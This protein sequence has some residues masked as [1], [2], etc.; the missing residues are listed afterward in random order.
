MADNGE[1]ILVEFDY[2]NIFVA[3]PNK[4]IDSDGRAKQRLVK[5]ENLVMYA[6]LEAEVIPRSKLTVG[7]ESSE[8]QTVSIAKI[9]FLNPSGE[10]YLTSN[11]IDAFTADQT[12]PKTNNKPNFFRSYED[13]PSL[14]S[15]AVTE[16]SLLGITQIQVKTTLSFMPEVSITLEDVR[17]RA[18]FELGDKSPYAAFFN[19]P[20]PKFY[21]TMKG[22]YGQAIRYQLMLQNFNASFDTNSGNFVV[23]LKFLT[24]KYSM[25]SEITMAYLTAAPYMYK[26][27]LQIKQP[28]LNP[29]ANLATL[30]DGQVYGGYEKIS[31]V[32]DE[33]ISKGLI[34]ADFP[35]LTLQQFQKK[36]DTFIKEVLLSFG[37]VNMQP[38]TD[39]DTYNNDLINYQKEVYNTEPG[40]TSWFTNYMDPNGVII[41][42]DTKQ[43][44]YPFKKNINPNDAI[45]ACK[46][47]GT[48]LINN[49]KKLDEN[50][51]MGKKG[52]FEVKN[53]VLYKSGGIATTLLQVD[54][55]NVVDNLPEWMVSKIKPNDVDFTA[56][57]LAQGNFISTNPAFTGSQDTFTE[58]LTLELNIPKNTGAT[59]YFF[60]FEGKNVDGLDA[61]IERTKKMNKELIQKRGEV[62]KKITD[63]L[64]KLLKDGSPFSIGFIPTIRNVLAVFFA[65]GE[66]F[67]RLMD[68]V[69]KKAYNQKDSDIRK[70]VVLNKTNSDSNNTFVYPWPQYIVETTVDGENVFEIKY[71][72]DANNAAITQSYRYDVW[73]EVEFVEELIKGY[74]QKLVDIPVDSIPDPNTQSVTRLMVNPIEYPFTNDAYLNKEEVK[75]IY[76]LWERMNFIVNYSRLTRGNPESQSIH[77]II[78]ETE[79]TNVSNSLGSSNV[80]LIKK[81]KDFALN[82]ANINSVLKH[83]SN[84]GEGGSW[85]TYARGF[86]TTNYIKNYTE[87]DW[88]FYDNTIFSKIINPDQ[89]SNQVPNIEKIQS[90]IKNTANNTPDF[91][92]TY[93]FTNTNYL[94]NNVANGQ[95][96]QSVDTFYDTKKVIEYDPNKK[97]VCNFNSNDTS[98]TKR[99]VTHFNFVNKTNILL[100]PTNGI[101]DTTTLKNFYTNRTGNNIVN[102]VATEG[103]VNYFSSG[104][105]YSGGVGSLQT[106]SLLNTPYFLN[107][108][109]EGVNR[110]KQNLNNPFVK[111]AYLFLNSLPL[112]TPSEKY[113]SSAGSTEENLDYI[114]SCFK[115]Y[116]AIHKIPYSLILKYGSIWYRYKRYIEDNV[117]ILDDVWTD[118]N[119]LNNY[120]PILSAATTT[121]T[122]TGIGDTQATTITLQ[123]QV[124]ANTTTKSVFNL[125]FYPKL[126]NDFSFFFNGY[127]VIS[128][129]SY[130][131]EAIQSAI[132]KYSLQVR[133]EG[134]ANLSQ[135]F[136]TTNTGRT[137]TMNYW[138]VYLPNERKTSL[139]PI[140]SFGNTFNQTF[141]ECFTNLSSTV[142]SP[143][144][145]IEVLDNKNMYNGSARVFWSAPN[146]GYFQNESLNKPA[147]DE[148]LKSLYINTDSQE[149]FLLNGTSGYTKIYDLIP[150]FKKTILDYFE[151]LFLKFCAN[152]YDFKPMVDTPANGTFG[153]VETSYQ[154]FHILFSKMCEIQLPSGQISFNDINSVKEQQFNNFQSLLN[155]F[156]TYDVLLK[157]GNVS[158]FDKITFLSLVSPNT[159]NINPNSGIDSVYNPLQF[160]SYNVNTPNALPTINNGVT[161][162]QSK[163]VYPEAWKALNLYIGD[164]TVEKIKFTDTG[165]TVFDFFIDNDIEFTEFNVTKLYPLIRI[166][167]TQ[168]SKDENYNK[169]KFFQGINEYIASSVE[170]QNS[171]FDYMM[172]KLNTS[173]PSVNET[174]VREV[175][176]ELFGTQAKVELWE[177][178][179][180]LNDK[181]IAGIDLSNRT[182]FEDV[183]LLD[184]ASRDIGDKILIDVNRLNDLLSNLNMKSNMLAYVKT[185]LQENNFQMMPLPAYVNFYNVDTPSKNPE[186]KLEGSLEFA[187]S[188]FGTFTSVDY[189]KSTSKMVCLYA[190][191]PSEHLDLKGQYRFKND[192]FKLERVGEVPLVEDQS[193]KKNWGMSNRVVGF[194]VDIGTTN[195]NIF[196]N[197]S[198]SQDAGKATSES[199]AI[200]SDMGSAASGKR[201]STQNVSLYNLYKNRSYSCSVSMMG[202]ALIQ[203]TMYFNLRH[204]PMFS[205]PYMIMEVEHNITPGTFDTTFKGI[206]QAIYSLPKLDSY[207]QSMRESLIT[208]IIDKA[209]QN[210]DVKNQSSANTPEQQTTS[211]SNNTNQ[212]QVN[213]NGEC[214]KNTPYQK[215][216]S[217]TPVSKEINFKDALNSLTA[218]TQSSYSDITK[219]NKA[220]YLI[221]SIMYLSSST[222]TTFKGNNWNMGAIRLNVKENNKEFDYGSR[223]IYFEKKFFCLQNNNTQNSFASFVD[224][225]NFISFMSASLT[226][227]TTNVIKFKDG[228]AFIKSEDDMAE[229]FAKFI[230]NLWPNK[231]ESDLF[232]SQKNS[233]FMK[234]RIK[235][236][237]EGI[238]VAKNLGL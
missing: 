219:R 101:L 45:K 117:D 142:S 118:F 48:I 197:F 73:P 90:Y 174:P 169:V 155:G 123:N 20:Y 150:T 191:K 173:L 27:S 236:I 86:Y 138:S 195:Q 111:S 82:S 61:F 58:K 143:T 188:L 127:D 156:M 201:S 153:E 65:N 49:N 60:A 37:E 67:L 217:T 187:N 52:D 66:G 97:V 237:K 204:V 83:I 158:N 199:L 212:S 79:F 46:D 206:R 235:T 59:S 148:Y 104:P 122:F 8:I 136:D 132:D 95:S 84:G 26:S 105:V 121:Y 9:N 151:D 159:V 15:N 18:L 112:S 152:R 189:R 196:T 3:D 64:N 193:G 177:T 70:N 23:R 24:Y 56:T 129:T 144:L 170:L 186:P 2:Q 12:K 21:L 154:N 168:K 107:S 175:V 120:D 145:S 200:I 225:E 31:S 99:P 128:G 77:E 13:D 44:V 126:I 115:K 171:S 215:Y 124:S 238:K 33:Y 183:L 125:G 103:S 87:Q 16:T 4:I 194:N 57:F 222:S 190:G 161:L 167:A 69:H 85:Q 205:G 172:N 5:H 28:Q 149:N 139:F 146:Y 232:T 88:Y 96:L 147:P 80:F 32:Y 181:W 71:P 54:D 6:N 224:F 209:K 176:S 130:T 34:P 55:R 160:R 223:D 89:S 114:F 43:R 50:P 179:K 53:L 36:L 11:Y 110:V 165:S 75:F 106:T 163:T 216:E 100:N 47:L 76:E 62:L 22:F 157:I 166:Y 102:Q 229:S 214:E 231:K 35:K 162:L 164:T 93:P 221:W 233:D 133:R 227:R 207:L 213:P 234:N 7:T 91:L 184:R 30:S 74:T 180:A 202:N 14:T 10:K 230:T 192:G 228:N 17:G 140:P 218:I 135:G 108:I 39:I 208:S 137:L 72:G 63:D 40:Q 131:N 42:N 141:N 185:I 113:K 220:N 51:V 98:S 119:Y 210:K 109:Q 68:D 78:G 178:L 94:K 226:D 81:L 198:V 41:L 182:L 38:L 92:D 25:L 29:L 116:S 211:N 203:P 19:L 1:N 134:F